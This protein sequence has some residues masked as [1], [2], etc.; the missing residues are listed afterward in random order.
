[1]AEVS[2]I[3]YGDT[4]HLDYNIEVDQITNCCRYNGYQMIHTDYG[5][6]KYLKLYKHNGYKQ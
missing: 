2:Q 1:M 6:E 3:N 4:I 5:P